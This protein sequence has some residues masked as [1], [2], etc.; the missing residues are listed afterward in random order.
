MWAAYRRIAIDPMIGD[1]GV[2]LRDNPV[3]PNR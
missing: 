2:L 1:C 3:V